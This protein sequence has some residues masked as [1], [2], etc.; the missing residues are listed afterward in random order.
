MMDWQQRTHVSRSEKNKARYI[1]GIAEPIIEQVMVGLDSKLA[2]FVDEWV[3]KKVRQDVDE[4]VEAKVREVMGN[5]SLLP[6]VDEDQ[7]TLVGNR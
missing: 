6:S 3:R 7:K 5:G 1:A 2:P 4:K